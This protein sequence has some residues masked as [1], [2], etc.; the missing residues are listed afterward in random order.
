MD[1]VSTLSA[2]DQY[3]IG[4]P[5][6]KLLR[7]VG[8]LGDVRLEVIDR[9]EL[10]FIDRVRLFLGFPPSDLKLSTIQQVAQEALLESSVSILESC[11]EGIFEAIKKLNTSIEHHNDPERHWFRTVFIDALSPP[12]FEAPSAIPPPKNWQPSS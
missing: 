7:R 5:G 11:K 9:S 3:G 10:G 2:L 6:T 12:S 4:P 8:T 1:V